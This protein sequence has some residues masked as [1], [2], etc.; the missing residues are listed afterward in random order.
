MDQ[1]KQ[2]QQQDVVEK[3][4]QKKR[5]GK[6]QDFSKLT[7]N[8]QVKIRLTEDEVEQLK[9]AAAAQDMTLADFVMT[10]ISEP[11]RIVI[12]GGLQ[13]WQEMV[14]EGRNLNYAIRLANITLNQQ[15][16]VPDIGPLIA[17]AEKIEQCFERFAEL[18][19]KWEAD[20]TEKVELEVHDADC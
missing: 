7:R 10:G 11:K 6:P 1:I 16:R 2:D 17:A 20:I 8:S 4:S 18:I 12:P 13:I 14:T 3:K 15:R 5:R 9:A 19:E